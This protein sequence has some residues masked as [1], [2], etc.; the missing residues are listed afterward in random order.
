M[1]RGELL[2]GVLAVFLASTLLPA[3]PRNDD[4]GARLG[5][6]GLSGQTTG[7]NYDATKE[8]GEPDHG[9]V[10]GGGS[11][12]WK[13]VAPRSGLATFF[14]LGSDFDT[15]M[16]VYTGI[17][18]GE[19]TEVA[20]NDDIIGRP[21]RQSL[22]T[23]DAVENREYQIAVD[24]DQGA[25]G[26]IILTWHLGFPGERAPDNNSFIDRRNLQGDSGRV[27]DTNRNADKEAGEPLHAGDFGGRSVWWN[28]VATDDGVL[29]L[30]TA[31][32]TFNTLLAIYTGDAVDR[33]TPVA[34]DDDGGGG[35]AS[36]LVFDVRAGTEYQVAVDGADGA[37]GVFV[38]KWLLTPPCRTPASPTAPIPGDG[39]GGIAGEV[40]L[41]WNGNAPLVRGVIYGEDGRHDAYEVADPVL[42]RVVDSTVAVV[43]K[44]DLRGNGDG[45]FTLSAET[46]GTVNDL[47][48]EER[49]R[50]QPASA[51]CSGF[52]VAPDLVVTAGHCLPTMADCGVAAFVFGYRMLDATTPVLTF[53][54]TQVYRCQ[55]IVYS[56]AVDGGADWAV[57]RLDRPV[58]DRE[59][60]KLRRSG[61]I[62]N[63]QSLVVVGYPAGLPVKIARGASVRDNSHDAFFVANLDTYVGSS[64][65]P[66]LAAG[67]LMVEGIIVRGEEDFVRQGDCYL[68]RRCPDD[69]PNG[70]C[71]GEEVTRSTEL[72]HL[73][74]ASPEPT[75]YEVLFGRCGE[76][77]SLGK[78]TEPFWA[79]GGLEPG[80]RYCWQ[81]VAIGD[82]GRTPGPVWSFATGEQTFFQRGDVFDDGTV[83]LTDAVRV[84]NF[85]FQGGDPPGCMRSA[86]VDDTGRVNLTDPVFLLN[87][88]FR[89]GPPPP[90]PFDSCGEDPIQD[91][92]TCGRQ[93]PCV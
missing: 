18:V 80:T 11:V 40:L 84:L 70:E 27:I 28:W 67:S 36:Y 24:G 38:L 25:Q 54:A 59:P 12:W 50:D 19:L 35:S 48:P 13:W 5:L 87:Y 37:G 53:P 32:S 20:S 74:P 78:T 63:S 29:T 57:V 62:G 3:M 51:V 55:D 9:G 65:S 69:D 16:G 77:V 23:F 14:T 6:S 22:V 10:R 56:R 47:C 89:G 76:P 43:L 46:F 68:S 4:F 17:G 83:N 39:A 15:T 79:V 72:A 60:L 49:F 41:R 8:P 90:P 71:T 75:A 61:R 30:E 93:E 42:G 2:L 66:V 92:L 34:Q 26:V 7:D 64:G 21:E 91:E 31:G 44:S 85:L 1:G 86:D 73:V 33:L 82:C 52:L 81:V 88:L 58:L 45:S